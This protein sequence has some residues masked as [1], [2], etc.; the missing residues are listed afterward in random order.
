MR[1]TRQASLVHGVVGGLLAGVSIALWFFVVDLFAGD[2]LHT[3]LE[4]GRA[5][6]GVASNGGEGSSVLLYTLLHFGT[7]AIVGALAAAFLASAGIAPRIGLGLFFGI[8]VL[9]AI[10]YVGLLL[11][12]ERLL[13]VLPAAHVVGANL[14]AGVLLMT[15]LHRVQKE[16]RPLG[17]A[18]LI[19]HPLLA[20]GLKVG[21]IGAG[22][23][24]V[25]F[26]LIDIAMSSPFHT[27][28]ALGSAVFLGAD[29]PASIAVTPAIV[30]AYTVLHLA[31]FAVIGIAFVATARSV[32]QLPSITL[33]VIMGGILLEAVTFSTLVAFG[34]WV[35]GSV[36]IWAVGVANLLAVAAMGG[37]IWREH[38]G[39]RKSVREGVGVTVT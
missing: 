3:P 14:L 37:W 9:T 35:L 4:L 1:S 15:H 20:E 2:P 10:H 28:A 33:Y 29:G 16:E 17:W 18:A 21:I 31:V 39:F 32:E 11:T 19:D 25:W 12:D 24:A 23:V 8:C 30:A 6:F 38:P 5:L 13:D 26:F 36:S 34:D 22:T 27:P 7:F